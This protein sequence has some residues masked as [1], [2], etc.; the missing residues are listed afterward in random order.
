[1]DSRFGEV[2][3]KADARLTELDERIS[4]NKL[5]IEK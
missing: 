5:G 4:A 3:E 1:M 2:D